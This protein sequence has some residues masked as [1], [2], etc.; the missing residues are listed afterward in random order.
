VTKILQAVRGMRDILPAETVIWQHVIGVCQDLCARYG[1][2]EIKLPILEKTQL[3]KRSIGDVT[4]IVEK[5]MYTFVDRNGDSLS[6]RP[7]GTACCVRAGIEHGLLYNQVQRL[8]Y[9]G[10]MFRHERPQKGRYRQFYQW[11]VE[12]F[13]VAQSSLDVEL[14]AMTKHLW[15]ELALDDL[16]LQLNTLGLPHEREKFRVDLQEFLRANIAALDEDSKHRIDSNPLRVLDSKVLATQEILVN[17]PKLADYL[18]EES[19]QHFAEV[20]AL[21]DSLEIAYEVNPCLV[22]GLD[23][24]NHTVFEWVTDKLGAQATVCAGGRYDRL[25]GQLGGK[26]TPAVGFSMGIERVVLLLSEMHDWQQSV[27]FYII[28]TAEN[29]KYYALQVAALLRDELDIATTIIDHKGGGIKSQFKRA[30]QA[31]AKYALIIGEDEVAAQTVTLRYLQKDA[32]QKQ[33]AIDDLVDE[34]LFLVM[35]DDDATA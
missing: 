26:D 35:E 19:K 1:Y 25:V 6:L 27:D 20:C 34:C 31:R 2:S 13:G 4:D 32:A 21:L 22:R 29:L 11:S 24:Y 28:T 12:A 17:A 3:F 23:Y 15:D 30:D 33:I 18:E 9:L 5:E 14:I 7:E 8:W 16:K 10:P